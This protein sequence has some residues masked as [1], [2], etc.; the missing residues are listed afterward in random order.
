MSADANNEYFSDGLSEELLNLLAKVDGLKVAA[1]TSSF[2]FKNS[3]ADIA[4][5]GEKLNVATVLEGSVRKSGNQARITAQLIKVDDGFHMWSETYDREL[6]NIFE[7]QDE[8]A[9]AIVDALSLPLLGSDAKPLESVASTANFEAYD[10]YLLGRH[11]AR[12][13]SEEGLK[14]ASEYFLKALEIDPSFASAHSGLADA[15]LLLADYSD[16]PQGEAIELARAAAE[17]ALA[18]DPSS[19]E[20]LSS[21]GLVMNNLGHYRDSGNYFEKA[22]QVNP[23]YVNALLWYSNALFNQFEKSKA[24]KMASRAMDVD[25]LS[26]NVRR[27]HTLQLLRSKRFDETESAIRAFIATDPDDPMPYELWGDLFM[28]RGLPH[29][30]IPMFDKAHRLRPGDIYMAAQNVEAG[31]QLDDSRLTAFWLNEAQNRGSVGRWTRTAE[32]MVMYANG[33]FDGLLQQVNQLLESSP[34][35]TRLVWFQSQALMNLGQADAAQEVLQEAL[36]S[37]GFISG[38]ALTGN[39]LFLAVQLANALDQNGEVTERDAL[40]GEI[41]K[42]LDQYRQSEPFSKGLLILQASVTSIQN[43]LPGLLHE[44]ETAAEKGFTEHW[45]LLSNPVFKRWQEH[46]DFIVF[47]QGMLDNAE[48]MRQQYYANNPA[49]GAN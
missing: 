36:H 33:D 18:I 35:Q 23:N 29:N 15:Y 25:P 7:V 20:A 2:K 14:R 46:P 48:A 49:E 39:Q 43:D 19:P 47:H 27:I 30:A 38:Q 22:L 17:K 10:L 12:E 16:L 28:A 40:L 1:R 37:A 4:E 8:I 11:H 45:E 32:N 31:L 13:Y 24:M 42:L 21:M 3:D 5:I 9:R 34:G 26:H 6:D 44:L 41:R